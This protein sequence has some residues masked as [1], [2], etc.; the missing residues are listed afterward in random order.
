[1]HQHIMTHNDAF[2]LIKIFRAVLDVDY[3]PTGREFVS[4]S[5]DKSIRIFPV[6]KPRS[7]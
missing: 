7:R 2:N 1:M 4:G 6:D 5:F 3:S